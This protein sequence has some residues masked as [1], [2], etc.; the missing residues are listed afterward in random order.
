MVCYQDTPK[1]D[2]SVSSKFYLRIFTSEAVKV[3]ES[4]PRAHSC[5]LSSG[6]QKTCQFWLLTLWLFNS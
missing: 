5:I 6:E 1:P 4:W 3:T 2:A